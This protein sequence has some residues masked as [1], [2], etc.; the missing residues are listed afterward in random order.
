MTSRE[1]SV[2]EVNHHQDLMAFIRFPWQIYQ[3]DRNWVPPL[4]K[5][6]LQ[7]FSPNH[8]FRSHSDFPLEHVATFG[9]IPG[10][11]LSDHL[12]FWRHGYRALMV[13]DTAFYRNPYYHTADDVPDKIDF[14]NFAKVV[15]G[16][17]DTIV[18]LA[19]SPEI[20]DASRVTS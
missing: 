12:S 15:N 19:D 5:D 18:E 7:K 13:T 3:G 16:L 14:E 8:P 9:V 20:R 10:I 2:E 11:S 4:I 1:L 6:Q 17:R